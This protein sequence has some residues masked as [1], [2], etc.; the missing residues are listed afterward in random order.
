MCL[1]Y[2]L[3]CFLGW[4]LVVLVIVDK[5]ITI[6]PYLY[7]E[8][9]DLYSSHVYIT[10]LVFYLSY[11]LQEFPQLELN[12]NS[13]EALFS[14]SCTDSLFFIYSHPQRPSALRW[15]V[16]GVGMPSSHGQKSNDAGA[17]TTGYALHDQSC[18]LCSLGQPRQVH[19][20]QPPMG[21]SMPIQYHFIITCSSLPILLWK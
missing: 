19:Q 8:S 18:Q 20:T 10:I 6:I 2:N 12:S 7:W 14:G 5:L 16:L 1:R 17:Q 15:M 11:S 4:I 21:V 9:S 3:R 13:P